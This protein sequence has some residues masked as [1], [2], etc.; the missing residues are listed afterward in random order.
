LASKNSSLPPSVLST[1]N[2]FFRGWRMTTDN[3][4]S[5]V[6]RWYFYTNM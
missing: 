2:R 3:P 5:R 4:L 6:A 1:F